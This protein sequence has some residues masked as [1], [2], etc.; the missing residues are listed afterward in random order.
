MRRWLMD[1]L[2]DKEELDSTRIIERINA[3]KNRSLHSLM[4]RDWAEFDAFTDALAIS[5]SLND[6]RTHMRKFVRYLET[7]IQEVSKRS[8]FQENPQ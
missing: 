1:V 2:G 5:I 3:F 7:L 8:V 6:I 4:Y